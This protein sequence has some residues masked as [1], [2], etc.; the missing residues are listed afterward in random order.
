MSFC[1]NINWS[2]VTPAL[3]WFVPLSLLAEQ[4]V[5]FKAD[6]API[7]LNQCQSCHGPK[8]AKGGYRVDT[9]ERAMEVDLEELHYRL[10]TDDEDEIMPPDAD[11]LP[12]EQ[13]A[14]FKR[15]QAEG[16]RFDG[17]D[18]NAS[19]AEIIPGIKHPD[20]PKQYP[21]AIPITAVAFSKDNQ[22]ILTSGYH[23]VLAWST[24]EGK[25][26]QRI[27]GLPERIHSI[28]IHPGGNQ[29]AV[30][31]GSPGRSGEVR[32]TNLADGSLV[33]LLHKSD[34][35]C[36]SAKFNPEGT[37]LATSGTDGTV[38][39]YDTTTWKETVSF[40]NHSS[41]VNEIAWSTD[42]TK[43]A[44][45]SKDRTAKVFDI[46]TRKRLSSYTGHDGS[47]YCL[48]FDSTGEHVYSGSGDGKLIAWKATD[49]S[50]VK[51]LI[52]QDT[53]VFQ[54]ADPGSEEAL[55]F[56]GGISTIKLINIKN[57]SIAR[58]YH[59]HESQLAL[60]V[61]GDQELIAAGNSL[62]H[63]RIF[64]TKSGNELVKFPAIPNL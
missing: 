38:R 13:I 6:L 34:D 14:L 9:F 64:E 42:S 2:G 10:E 55:I 44:S 17:S 12:P 20:P 25:L 50:T 32:V 46:A 54:I 23:E 16:E 48:T 3:F 36:L 51:E 52:N 35:L 53:P 26:Q 8:K 7:L 56:A 30:A 49:G 29:M 4:P 61:S 63:I 11:P 62:G 47:V 41:W 27:T 21:R 57:S 19:L 39:V 40:A 1:F 15:W 33:K 18:G 22:T 24:K 5:S 59:G 43:L 31:G 45:G 28:D 58:E 37:S 60:T